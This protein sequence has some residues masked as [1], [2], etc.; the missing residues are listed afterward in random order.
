MS[1]K[2]ITMTHY[3]S[4]MG[5]MKG[6]YDT[7]KALHQSNLENDEEINRVYGLIETNLIKTKMF[8][9]SEVINLFSTLFVYKNK[10]NRSNFKIFKRVYDNYPPAQ[11]E[12]LSPPF[13]YYLAKLYKIHVNS[14]NHFVDKA[15]ESKNPPLGV[16]PNKTVMKAIMNDDIKSLSA[17]ASNEKFNSNETIINE[18]MIPPCEYNY[19]EL[20]CYYGSA[21]CF[22]FLRSKFNTK[23]TENCLLFSFLGGNLKIVNECLLYQKPN[24]KC[25]EYAIFSFN[26]DLILLLVNKYKIQIEPEQCSQCDNIEAF[27]LLME[28]TIDY[29]KIFAIAPKFQ[30]LE[31]MKYL[32]PLVKNINVVDKDGWTAVILASYLNNIEILQFLISN[33]AKVNLADNLG[34]TPL[35][36][37]VNLNHFQIAKLLVKNSADINAKDKQDMSVLHYAVKGNNLEIFKLLISHDAIIHVTDRDGISPFDSALHMCNIEI[38]KYLKSKGLEKCGKF[39][40]ALNDK[41]INLILRSAVISNQLDAV[42]NLLN[43]GINPNIPDPYGYTPVHYAIG[44]GFSD[45]FKILEMAGGK[46]N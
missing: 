8:Q 44:L 41:N 23:I 38:I 6:H 31:I 46:I 32:Y 29:D 43:A 39:Q 9:F 12:Q 16:F 11:D 3:N 24:Q 42:I 19:L 18:F 22:M 37:A 30:L 28:Q 5:L 4:I 34:K 1:I 7:F 36:I 15:L 20:C 33:G 10:N 40:R 13:C 25:M 17:Y 26:K 14:V 35:M 2:S 27:A 21:E 45:M